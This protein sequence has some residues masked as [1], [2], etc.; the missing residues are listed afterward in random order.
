MTVKAILEAKGHDVF[1]LGP[2]EKLSEAIKLLADHRVG[3]L[4]ERVFPESGNVAETSARVEPGIVYI[5]QYWQAWVRV[6]KGGGPYGYWG[7]V[8][9]TS[10]QWATRCSGFIVNP[11]R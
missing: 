5:E 7:W 6:P 4:V 9:D 10:F 1:T 8:G 3:A 2:N 11:V